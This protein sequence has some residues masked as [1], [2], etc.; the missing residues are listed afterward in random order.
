MLMKTPAAVID[1]QT[2]DDGVPEY[3]APGAIRREALGFVIGFILWVLFAYATFKY[4]IVPP[5]I[6]N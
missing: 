1:A 2:A 5:D 3:R 6:M 4:G